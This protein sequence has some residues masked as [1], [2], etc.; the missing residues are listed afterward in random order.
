MYEFTDIPIYPGVS[1]DVAFVVDKS[2]SHEM[3][4]T[5]I[6][7]A[8]GKLLYCVDLFDVFE[9][10]NKLGKDKKQLAFRIEYLDFEKTLTK[11]IVDK[12]HDRLIK[13]VC[14]STGAEI[15]N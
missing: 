3:L 2:V 11:D 5:R 1:I 14:A 13:K 10:A 7:S 12:T 9:D 6:S 15:R 8:G 4:K